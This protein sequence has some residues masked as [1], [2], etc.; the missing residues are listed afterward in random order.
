MAAICEL[1]GQWLDGTGASADL[2]MEKAGEVW[3]MTAEARRYSILTMPDCR[4]RPVDIPVMEAGGGVGQVRPGGVAL[5]RIYD[6]T[7]QKTEI[8]VLPR[9]H[10]SRNSPGTARGR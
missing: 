6:K 7:T 1:E 10:P 3:V 2:A 5:Y 4:L 8:Y 9:A